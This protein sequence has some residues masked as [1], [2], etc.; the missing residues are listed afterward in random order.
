M[1][2]SSRRC[3]GSQVVDVDGAWTDD[4]EAGE[5]NG[6]YD[7]ILPYTHLL[8]SERVINSR[9]SQYDLEHHEPDN[10]GE[11][12]RRALE[13]LPPLSPWPPK[14]S[15]LTEYESSDIS[16][17]PVPLFSVGPDGDHS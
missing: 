5:V 15:E 12:L 14:D 17:D 1:F 10:P 8:G 7:V 4:V 16:G 13:R 9:R 2:T 6:S 3:L 11:M